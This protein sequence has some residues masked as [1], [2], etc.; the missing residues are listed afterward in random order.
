MSR[1]RGSRPAPAGLVAADASVDIVY[2]WSV[3]THI[4]PE[5]CY[6]YLVDTFRALKPGGKTVFSFLQITEPL[7]QRVFDGR[8][9]RLALGRSSDILDPFLH[10]DWIA[11][12]AQRIGFTAPEFTAG[13]DGTHHPPFWQTLATMTKP[14]ASASD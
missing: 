7:H 6:L 14:Q 8:A 5:E 12:W 4:P 13:D 1:L 11:T 10:K 3:F 9:K 2:H